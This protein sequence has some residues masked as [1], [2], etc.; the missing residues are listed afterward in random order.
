M[1]NRSEELVH[2]LGRKIVNGEYL[3]GEI[4]PKAEVLSE[5]HGVSRTV[6]RE[7]LK[8]LATRKLIRS[9]QRSG[10]SVLPRA[11][12][13]WWDIDVLTW[14]I[15]D[16]NNSDFILHL[17]DVRLGLEPMAAALAAKRAT[18]QDHVK[19]KAC[20][21]KLEQSVGDE[22]AWAKADFEFH[23][24]IL[25]ASYNDLMI[26]TIQSLHKALIISR[27]KTFH[28]VKEYADPTFDSPTKEVLDRHRAIYEAVLAR[29]EDLARQKM[30]DLIL[31][32]KRLL[33]EIYVS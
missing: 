19:I 13:Q 24:S 18:D 31:R 21:E 28:A 27:E 33:E 11:M 25:H 10:T 26:G 30:T 14:I 9:N 4:L 1:Q 6:V 17:T 3:P 8:G 29:D 12:W 20:F 16:E 23:Q 7:A 5:M 32:V 15:E 22:R 2:E